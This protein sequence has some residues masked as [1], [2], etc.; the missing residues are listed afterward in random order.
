MSR[1]S[2]ELVLYCFVTAAGKEKNTKPPHAVLYCFITLQRKR[3][4]ERRDLTAFH[5]PTGRRL[6]ATRLSMEATCCTL[7]G[8]H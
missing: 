8:G 6:A 7:V 1:N 4:D 2:R 3:Q 5:R